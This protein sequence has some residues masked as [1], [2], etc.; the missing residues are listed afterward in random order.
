M[1]NTYKVRSVV[2]RIKNTQAALD[3]ASNFNGALMGMENA[4]KNIHEH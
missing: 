4:L 3:F 2:V 1:Q